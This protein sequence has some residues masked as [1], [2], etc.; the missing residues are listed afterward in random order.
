MAPRRTVTGAFAFALALPLAVTACN[1]PADPAQARITN[2]IRGNS[3]NASIGFIRLLA[4]RIDTPEERKA[5]GGTNTGLYATIANDGN[6]SDRLVSV[7]TVY[8]QRVVQR[9]GQSGPESPVSVDLP[10]QT[11][12]SLQYP[13]GLHLEMVDLKVDVRAGR[14]LPVTFR[15]ERA[16]PLT[17]YVFVDGFGLQT[18]S[19]V[20]PTSG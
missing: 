14:F 19:P 17:V 11:A 1:R 5:Q 4:T 13:G 20:S 12:V 3:V 6:Q 9:Q 7:S 2:A 8:A 16:G 15:F 10:P 18:V